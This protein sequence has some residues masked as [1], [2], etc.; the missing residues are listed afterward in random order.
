MATFN[1]TPPPESH[2]EDHD[3]LSV[4][5]Y[6]ARNAAGSLVLCVRV[7]LPGMPAYSGALSDVLSGAD[8]TALAPL[9]KATV[10]GA[11]VAQGYTVTL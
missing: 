8:R 10:R 9:L 11:A 3:E 1:R 6:K 2:D 7:T 5:F 4:S